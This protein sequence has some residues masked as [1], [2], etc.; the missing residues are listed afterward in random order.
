M[1]YTYVETALHSQLSILQY[2]VLNY[3]TSCCKKETPILDSLFWSLIKWIQEYV[4]IQQVLFSLVNALFIICSWRLFSA[5]SFQ[6]FN[7]SWFIYN[8]SI[9]TLFLISFTGNWELFSPQDI[10][11]NSVLHLESAFNKNLL[12]SS[13]HTVLGARMKKTVLSLNGHTTW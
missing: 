12:R 5:C 9:Y 11:Q 2:V 10:P 6:G 4:P 13:R 1:A 8:Y 7:S 3:R